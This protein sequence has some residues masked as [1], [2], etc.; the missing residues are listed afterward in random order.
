MLVVP[1]QPLANQTLQVQL[2]N[3]PC[4]LHIYQEA[5]G[6][7]INV[8]INNTLIIAGVICEDRNRIVRSTY[9]G[10]VG[11]FIFVDTQGQTDPIY[12]G[13]GGRYQLVYLESADLEALES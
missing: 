11:D 6:L 12:T 3:Q 1:I 8:Y 4:T 10:F 2:A 5:Y 13:L 9:L 7:Y